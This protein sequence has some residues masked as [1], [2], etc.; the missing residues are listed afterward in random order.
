MK[1]EMDKQHKKKIKN[2]GLVCKGIDIKPL[3]HSNVMYI[4]LILLYKYDGCETHI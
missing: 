4:R 3:K 1:R 2:K